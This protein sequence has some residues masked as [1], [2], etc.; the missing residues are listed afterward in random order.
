MAHVPKKHAVYNQLD[1][2]STSIPLNIV[3][4]NGKYLPRNRYKF[5]EI[6]RDQLFECAAALDVLVAKGIVEKNKN[7]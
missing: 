1:R 7:N 4:G 3:E 5:L 2:A 6:D